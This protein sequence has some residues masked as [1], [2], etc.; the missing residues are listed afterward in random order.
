MPPLTT[1][2]IVKPPPLPGRLPEPIR[3]RLAAVAREKAARAEA[4]RLARQRAA[5]ER[6]RAEAAAAK[7]VIPS[8]ETAAVRRAPAQSPPAAPLSPAT[9]PQ[10]GV[11]L[12]KAETIDALRLQWTLLR[13]KYYRHLKGLNARYIRSASSPGTQHFVLVAGPVAGAM[14]ALE[15]CQDVST[16]GTPCVVG[17][18]VGNAL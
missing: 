4:E 14:Q 12:S 7:R 11:R 6:A 9:P 5:A 17:D 16:S 3:R 15:L 13:A 2:S 1:G 10:M 18:F 8:F